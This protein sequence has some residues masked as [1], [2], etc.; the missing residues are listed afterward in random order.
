MGDSKFGQLGLGNLKC[1]YVQQPTHLKLG[2][3]KGS[4][5]DICAGFRQSYILTTENQIFATGSNKQLELGCKTQID[6]LFEPISFQIESKTAVQEIKAGQRHV[7]CLCNDGQVIGWGSNKFGQ[8]GRENAENTSTY[9]PSQLEI[10]G[11]VQIQTGWNHTM[12]LNSKRFV[13]FSEEQKKER[14]YWLEE[15]TL[16]NKVMAKTKIDLHSTKLI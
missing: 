9:L 15:E 3:F 11:I 6:S 4:I 16:A 5:Q 13:L 10:D 7:V 8:L 14:Y 1:D 2:E 12:V